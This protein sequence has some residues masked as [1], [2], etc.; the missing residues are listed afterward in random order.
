MREAP[1]MS[2]AKDTMPSSSG[3]GSL[4]NGC[5][6]ID[7][8]GEDSALFGRMVALGKGRSACGMRP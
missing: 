4:R 8:A 7:L 2:A 5:E 6:L 3:V 1:T